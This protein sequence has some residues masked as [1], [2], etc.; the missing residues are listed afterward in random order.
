MGDTENE[1]INTQSFF[2]FWHSIK[3]FI[4]KVDW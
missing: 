1:S 2:Q 3:S 4:K